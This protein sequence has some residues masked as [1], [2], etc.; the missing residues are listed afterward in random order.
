LS[1][2]YGYAFELYFTTRRLSYTLRLLIGIIFEFVLSN[3]SSLDSFVET[4]SDYNSFY[5]VLT[6]NYKSINQIIIY[7]IQILK[8]APKLWRNEL[9]SKPSSKR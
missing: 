4:R 2:L 9:I 1:K 8:D 5:I 6:A 3:G 7:N